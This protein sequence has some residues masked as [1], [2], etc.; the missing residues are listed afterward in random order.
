MGHRLR[1]PFLLA[2]AVA[3]LAACEPTHAVHPL[4]GPPDAAPDDAT[5]AA[6]FTLSL[7]WADQDAVWPHAPLRLAF[8]TPE[9]EVVRTE[10]L[11]DAPPKS[12]FERQV[13]APAPGRWRLR[14]YYDRDRDGVF[15]GCPYP[16]SPDDAERADRLDN[17]YGVVERVIDGA[18]VVTV[19]LSRH[20][21]GPGAPDTGY[22]GEV[23]PPAEANLAG[24]PVWVELDPTPMIRAERFAPQGADA[25]AEPPAAGP[26]RI[27][28]FPTGITG[29]AKFELG[30]LLPGP[31]HATFYADEDG[32]GL[33]S[34]CGAGVGGGDRFVASLDPPEVAAGQLA[35]VGALHLTR[36]PGCPDALTGVKGRF[37]L[38]PALAADRKLAAGAVRLAVVNPADGAMVI[39]SAEILPG[40]DARPLP[41]PFTVTGLPAGTWRLALYLD[42]DEDGLFGP[43]GGLAGG[44]D[45]VYALRDA[46][47]VRDGYVTDL[48]D[49][50]L[51]RASECEP[52]AGALR[53]RVR[54][55]SEPGAVGSGRPVRVDFYPGDEAGERR[56][57][58]VFE[59]HVQIAAMADPDG[60]VRFTA[61]PGIPP[62]HYQ[63]RI[64][65]DTDRDGTYASCRDAPFADR[66]SSPLFPVE[67]GPGGLIDVGDHD[68]ALEGCPVPDVQLAP[69]VGVADGAHLDGVGEL[70]LE[71]VEAGG[72]RHDIRLRGRVDLADLPG[73][74][75]AAPPL[76]ELAPGVWHLTAYLDTQ[77][78]M[79]FGACDDAAPDAV[80][81]SVEVTLDQDTPAASP[82][83]RLER[84]CR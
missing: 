52:D 69:I 60:Y 25:G 31:Y 5:P 12:A 40:V 64:Y 49:V 56:S 27:P 15:A 16:P 80:A 32:D 20:V 4:A 35:S 30:E 26:L 38:P 44:I 51:S 84:V 82:V 10:D 63:A 22:R 48:G 83:I 76:D 21:C 14:V 45:V 37:D 78:D 6:G 68:V 62:G 65:L 19:E 36:A 8:E 53:G 23:D 11:G 7:A 67:V 1:P 9:G 28:L 41:H 79:R 54:L 43:C 74:P 33:P 73:A 3:G 75:Y 77:A 70:R 18:K 71:L 24:V 29:A 13:T 47:E 59:N 55:P 2:L 17:V 58:L 42:R 39:D 50:E 34:A 57:V 66:A 61:T 46:V 72:W 81:G